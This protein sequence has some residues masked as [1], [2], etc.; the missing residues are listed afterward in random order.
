[1]M[2]RFEILRQLGI[3][4]MLHGSF[5]LIVAMS[6][7]AELDRPVAKSAEK[8]TPSVV[9]RELWPGQA[10]VKEDLVRLSKVESVWLDK[11]RKIVIVGGAVCTRQGPLEMFACPRG[12]KEYESVVAVNSKAQT[13]HAALLAVGVTPGTP[14]EFQ[15]KYKAATGPIIEILVL[16]HDDKTKKLRRVHAQQWVRHVKSQSAMSED[17]VF[18][19][20]GFWKDPDTGEEF[21]QA[22]GGELI[23]VSNFSTAT[24]DLPVASPQDNQGLYF[25]AFTENIPPLG[26]RV[27][28]ALREKK[29][30]K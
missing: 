26:T 11:K 3:I 22:E 18:A 8:T 28:L 19:G 5:V 1:M 15:P 14:V 24:L 9:P 17:W 29:T 12:T 20:S 21:Y 23:C 10:V 7:A 13:V 4:T 27:W 25:D 30:A 6:S 2:A 16:W